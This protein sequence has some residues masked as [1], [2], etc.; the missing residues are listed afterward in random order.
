MI[1]KSVKSFTINEYGDDI[2]SRTLSIEAG[3]QELTDS[4]VL[5]SDR[6]ALVSLEPAGVREWINDA[7]NATAWGSNY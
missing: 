1:N 7:T 5:T 2:L 3:A 6:T 4:P